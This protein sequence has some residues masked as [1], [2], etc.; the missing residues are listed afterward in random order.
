MTSPDSRAERDGDAR[1]SFDLRAVSRRYPLTVRALGTLPDRETWL[2]RIHELGVGWH[3]A[4]EREA[5]RTHAPEVITHSAPPAGA[6]VEAEFDII[7]AGGVLGLLHAATMA[8]RFDR[9]VLVFDAHTV[10]RTH[11]DWN[12]SDAELCEFE[13]A[14]LFTVAELQAAIVNRYRTGFVKFHDANSRIKTPPLWMDNVLDV[15]LDS[16]RLLALARRKIEQRKGCELR[17]RVR[18]RRAYVEAHR[19]TIE[20]EDERGR[21]RFFAA[22]LFVDATGAN[23]SVAGQLNDERAMTHVCPTVGTVARGFVRGDLA[24]DPGAIDFSVGEILVSTEDA[25]EHRQLIW[26][27]FAGAPAR[28]DYTT[29]LFFY[30]AVDSPADKSLFSL[31]ENYFE[32][33]PAYK[34][35]GSAW[36]VAKPVFGFIPA[37]HGGAWT[38][39]KRTATE[40]VLTVGDAAGLSSALTFCGFGSHVRNLRRL[41]ESTERRLAGD[42]LDEAALREVNAY[43][44]RV[45]QMA[46]LAE[47][48]R[49]TRNNTNPAAVNETMNAVCQALHTLDE[50]VRR[51]LFQDRMS[52]RALRLLLGRTARLYPTIFRRVREHLGVRGTLRWLTGIAEAAWSERRAG[53]APETIADDLAPP[54]ALIRD[55][56]ERGRA[57]YVPAKTAEIGIA[58][59]GSS[60]S[61]PS[62]EGEARGAAVT[63]G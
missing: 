29:Y 8:S 7:Y 57:A 63:K 23:S 12:I 25:S 2:R 59:V 60:P 47:F 16:D 10:G 53:S 26:E 35:Q 61:K 31:F 24:R 43:E 54:A 44:P 32:R 56:D 58:G 1:G 34:R 3:D 22:R 6:T 51:E 36:R 42:A 14:G 17:D 27:G 19:V 15:A 18:F 11:R 5:R 55:V 50:E 49:P 28:D 20:T 9:R 52:A 38:N 4:R 48:M 40:R 41:T 30:D 13:R 21:V 46:S 39:R 37:H 45:A 33:L 62:V